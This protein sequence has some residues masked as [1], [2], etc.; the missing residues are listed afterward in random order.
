MNC[1]ENGFVGFIGTLT[2]ILGENGKNHW[3]F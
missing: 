1:V 2:F 3:K